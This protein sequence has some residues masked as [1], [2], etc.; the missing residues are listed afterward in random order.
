MV[1][2]LFHGAH[3]EWAIF[4]TAMHAVSIIG[5]RICEKLTFHCDSDAVSTIVAIIDNPTATLQFL[6]RYLDFSAYMYTVTVPRPMAW[7]P[8]Q[9]ELC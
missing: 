2:S 3:K 9:I 8:G 4:H 7:D 6:S 1:H 5:D